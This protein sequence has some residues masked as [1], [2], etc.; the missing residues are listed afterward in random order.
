MAS[1]VSQGSV[2]G[3]LFFI[4]Y[5]ADMWNYLE[6]KNISYAND[7]TLY[8]KVVSLYDH[9]NVANFLNRDLA[10]VKSWCST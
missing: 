10:K 9:I 3:P 4:L 7:T 8:A 6:N 1:D 2:L 5:T